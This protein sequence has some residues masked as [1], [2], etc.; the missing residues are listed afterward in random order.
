MFYQVAQLGC[1]QARQYR[2][3]EVLQAPAAIENPVHAAA[4]GARIAF[5]QRSRCPSVGLL[6]QPYIVVEGQR[7]AQGM[8]GVDQVAAGQDG[9][10][11]PRAPIVSQPG[12][13]AVERLFGE[14]A[15]GVESA[16]QDRQS[17]ASPPSR[18]NWYFQGAAICAG[19]PYGSM[20]APDQASTTSA[21]LAG[22]VK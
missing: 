11:S 17:G 6:L 7:L 22:A 21:G 1:E 9:A 16:A 20:K 5:D 4:V 2:C 10:G 8:S 18:R 13:K 15:A 19:S 3:T 12:C 14:Q